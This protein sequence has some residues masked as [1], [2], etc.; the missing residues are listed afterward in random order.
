MRANT[1]LTQYLTEK[2]YAWFKGNRVV[3]DKAASIALVLREADTKEAEDSSAYEQLSDQ[4]RQ[5]IKL[6]E[7]DVVERLKIDTEFWER[8]MEDIWDE[9]I[10]ETTIVSMFLDD[11]WEQLTKEQEQQCIG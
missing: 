3:K 11:A 5:S 10:D 9:C 2:A 7:K 8:V 1:Q 6:L 4:A